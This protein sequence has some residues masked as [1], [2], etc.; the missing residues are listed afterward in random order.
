MTLGVQIK[1]GEGGR[2][3]KKNSMCLE[4]N[5][6]PGFN[7]EEKLVTRQ[8]SSHIAAVRIKHKLNEPDISFLAQ[9][10]C[11]AAAPIVSREKL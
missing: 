3:K 10:K 8:G 11:A 1:P 4:F 5:R 7:F 9:H 6:I 2:K